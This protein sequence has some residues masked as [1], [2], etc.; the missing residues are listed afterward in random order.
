MPITLYG[1]AILRRRAPDVVEFGTDLAALIDRMFETLYATEHGVGLSANQVGRTER[2]FIF[3]LRD[4]QIGHVVNPVVTVGSELE[5]DDEACL[6]VPGIGPIISSAMVA[7]MRRR[8]ASG[9]SSSGAVSSTSKPR[10]G[11]PRCARAPAA[12]RSA[13]GR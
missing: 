7:A 4:G 5:R 2:V 9:A 13:C 8:C 11:R 1:N 6:S 10:P 12:C 3:D